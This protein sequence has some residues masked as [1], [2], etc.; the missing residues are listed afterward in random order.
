VRVEVAENYWRRPQQRLNHLA[1]EA[2]LIGQ[3]QRVT[4]YYEM[5]GVAEMCYHAMNLLRTYAGSDGV[6][7]EV[8]AFEQRT[9]LV[10]FA[11]DRGVVLDKEVWNL[12]L[13]SYANGVLGANTQCSTWNSPLRRSLPKSVTIE[14]TLGL[15]N[16]GRGVLNAIYRLEN[17]KEVRYPMETETRD[18]VPVRYYY[19]TNPPVEFANP[20][21]DRPLGYGVTSYG[22]DDDISR[23]HELL[24]L[25]NSV[26]DGQPAAYGLAEG[27]IDQELSIAV[28]ESSRLGGEP[29]RLPLG[30]ETPWERTQNDLF[31]TR[32]GGDPVRD[33]DAIISR[34]LQ[35]G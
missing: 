23:A 6:G 7:S 12:A 8:R 11:N 35:G 33:A 28:N 18:K 30:E 24:S 14:G 31:R 9:P 29:V 34:I 32:W 5:G 17:G 4:S 16:A 26:V 13:V 19:E 27:R 3:V 20:F 22:P 21:A 25:Y 15:I 2:G 10:P 1:I